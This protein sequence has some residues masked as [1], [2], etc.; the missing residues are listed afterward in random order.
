[1]LHNLKI[2]LPV[3][4]LKERK[5]FIAY[6]PALD[7]STAGKSFD[8]ALKRFDEAVQI[9]FEEM[10]EE[11]NTNEVLESLGWH[12]QKRSWTPPSVIAHDVRSFDIAYA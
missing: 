11:G 8:E 9:F 1:M 5:A 6:S 2:Q 12:R 7:L 3:S 4:I 10:A